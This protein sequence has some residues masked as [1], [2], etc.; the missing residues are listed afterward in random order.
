MTINLDFKEKNVPVT[1]AATLKKLNCSSPI[2][3]TQKKEK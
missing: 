2:E 1:R 3:N